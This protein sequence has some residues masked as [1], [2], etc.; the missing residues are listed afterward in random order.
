MKFKVLKIIK[1]RSRN[2]YI[3]SYLQPT[4]LLFKNFIRIYF[5]S[6]DKTGVSRISFLDIDNLDD[7]NVIRESKKYA[8]DIGEDG[9]FDDNGVVP[10]FAEKSNKN[11]NLYYAG[12]QIPTKTKFLVFTGLAKSKKTGIKFQRKSNTPFLDR[13]TEGKLFIV[14][15]F[16]YKKNKINYFFYGYGSKLKGKTPSYEIG[17]S[18]NLNSKIGHIKLNSIKREIRIARPNLIKYKKKYILFF[19]VSTSK[20]FYHIEFA[21]SF[22]L[23]HWKRKGKIELVGSK[24]ILLQ[25]NK[26]QA[27]PYVVKIKNQIYLLFNG[28]N[29]GKDGILLSKLID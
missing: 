2:K 6:R 17:I 26:M 4:V 16:I 27:Y 12:Y 18:T 13:S 3:S 11:I 28:N 1:S 10:T 23:K 9:C 21:E 8:L 24:K 15:H 20:S 22:D 14:I 5:G 25:C 7:G 19:C 29:F